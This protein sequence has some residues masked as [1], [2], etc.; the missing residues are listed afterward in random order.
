MEDYLSQLNESQRQAVEC[1]EGPVMIIAGAGSGKTRVLTYRVAHLMQKGIDPFNIL[2]LTFTNKAAREMKNRIS[3]LTGDEARNLWMGTFHSVFAR[4]LRVEAHRLGFPSNFTIYDSDDSK[5]LIRTI[6]REQNLDDKVY[7]PS[8]V[9]NRISSAKNNLMSYA[10]YAENAELINDDRLSGKPHL[11]AIFELYTKR[12]FKAGAM[13]FDDLLYFTYMLLKNFPDELNKYQHKFKYIMVDEFQD[14]NFV[15]YMIVRKIAALNENICVVGDDAQSIYAFRGANI[16]N[17]L[18]FEKDYP[19]LNIFKL[20]QN[21]RSTKN[22]VNAANSVIL[23]NRNQLRKE[24]WTENDHGTKIKVLRALS[25]N[26]EGSIVANSIFHDKMN[27][28]LHNKDFAILYRTNAQ[29]RSMEEAL[30][31]MN[32][33]YRIYGGLSFYSRKEIKDVLAYFRLTINPND[34]EALKRV[35]NY[36][37]RGIGQTSVD[38]LV[39]AADQTGKS[40][41]EVLENIHTI[42]TGIA[43]NTREKI[44]DFVSMIKSFQVMMKSHNAY[45]LASHIA[46]TTGLLRELYNDKT[47]EGL[48]HYENIQELLNGIKEFT[49]AENF[50]SGINLP[51]AEPFSEI[52][53]ELP[54]YEITKLPE[55]PINPPNDQLKSLDLYMQDIALLTDAENK[56]DGDNNKVSLM[57]IHS[58]KGLEFKEVFVVGL[59]ENLFPSQMS[60]LSRADLE[61]ERRLFYVAMTRAEKML[62]LTY[63]VSRYR[64]GNLIGCEPSRFLEEVHPDFIEFSNVSK[65]QQNETSWG[66]FD[67]D[68]SQSRLNN[69]RKANFQQKNPLMPKNN[70]TPIYKAYKPA[71]AASAENDFVADD[72]SQIVIGMEVEHQKFGTG[73]VINLEGNFPDNK[74]TVF[75]PAEGNKQLL[76]KYA[77]L[78]IVK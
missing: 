28:Q 66:S 62:T 31:R 19:D 63:A 6:L 16:Q 5:S 47:P 65:K 7:K 57:T 10:E 29:S 61:E 68:F 76:L 53:D 70:F 71:S 42:S 35:I 26:E 11:A 22:I 78:K 38:K 39:V 54:D 75:F 14:T 64:W 17:I 34:E 25:D 46:N 48:A 41:W 18:S 23:N 51:T 67:D 74:A 36:P 44:A 60:M 13:D 56:D 77:K 32:I 3:A 27:Y 37:A 2:S 9:L 24:V 20:E 30:R 12:C 49:T 72:P 33:P 8:M 15:Q 43:T 45:D 21:Y 1:T 55:I 69:Q 4:I 50:S 73:K 40:I 59:E 58:A 52:T